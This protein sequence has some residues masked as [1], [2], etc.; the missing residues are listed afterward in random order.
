MNTLVLWLMKYN[1]SQP[2]N[3]VRMMGISTS[4]YYVMIMDFNWWRK[5]WLLMRLEKLLLKW[6]K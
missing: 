2:R 1:W 4:F 6:G 3:K 5:D